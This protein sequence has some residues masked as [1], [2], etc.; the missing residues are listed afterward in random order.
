VH[1]L[2]QAGAVADEVQPPAGTLTLG[3]D[4][5]VGQPDRRHEIAPREFGQHPGVDP[6]GLARER[7]EPLHFLRIGDL[8]LP[9]VQLELVVHEPGAVHRLDRGADRRTATSKPLTQSVQPIGIRRC[10]T[11]VH[12]R[13]LVIE[14]AKVETLATEI[15]SGVQHCVGPPFV[16]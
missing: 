1:A 12:G 13:T 7:C 4:S 8:D 11:R 2:L 15:Q 6:V 5:W 16:S 3:A 9:T 14:H 10:G